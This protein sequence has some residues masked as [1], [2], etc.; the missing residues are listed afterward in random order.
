MQIEEVSLPTEHHIIRKNSETQICDD[1]HR[2]FL[3]NL[4]REQAKRRRTVNLEDDDLSRSSQR[5]SG[6]I[7]FGRHQKRSQVSS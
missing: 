4:E 6:A 5:N 2:K 1:T 3:C 7:R